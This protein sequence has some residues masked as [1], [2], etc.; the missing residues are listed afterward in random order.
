[1]NDEFRRAKRFKSLKSITKEEMKLKGKSI[2]LNFLYQ[3]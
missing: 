2:K 3:L 1:M